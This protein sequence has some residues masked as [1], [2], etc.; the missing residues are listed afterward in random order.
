MPNS[1]NAPTVM[2]ALPDCAFAFVHTG[3]S[4]LHARCRIFRVFAPVNG[5]HSDKNKI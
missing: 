1:A 5:L 2:G 3:A 4:G